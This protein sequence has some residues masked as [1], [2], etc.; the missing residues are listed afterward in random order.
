MNNGDSITIRITGKEI[1]GRL[2]NLERMIKVMKYSNYVQ[3]LLIVLILSR[4]FL[5]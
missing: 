2:T 4:L 1:V 5:I 3:M